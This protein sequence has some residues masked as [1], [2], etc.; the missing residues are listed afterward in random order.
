M[1]WF[2]PLALLLVGMVVAGCA[3]HKRK[4]MS[5]PAATPGAGSPQPIVTPAQSPVARVVSYDAVGR[6]VILSFPVG[7][8]PPEG[9]TLSLYRAGLKVGEVRITGPQNEDNVVADLIAGAAQ[10]GDEAR[11]Q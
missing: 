10:V 11:E 5:G 1:K 6:F 8:M 4:P 7:Q 3:S 9:R 2:T